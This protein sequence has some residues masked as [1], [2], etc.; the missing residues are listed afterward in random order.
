MDI[1]EP[2]GPV[3]EISVI[4]SSPSN[5]QVR[6][7]SGSSML[8]KLVVI[9]NEVLMAEKFLVVALHYKK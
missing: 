1:A 6:S 4:R 8:L 7:S 5:L 9:P 3:Q 2:S